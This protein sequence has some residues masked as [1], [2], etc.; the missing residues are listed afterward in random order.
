MRRLIL[1][2]SCL[3]SLPS[4]SFARDVAAPDAAARDAAAPYAVGLASI[5]EAYLR[6]WLEF[7]AAPELAGRDTGKPG[8]DIACRYIESVLKGY[9][10]E[11]AGDEGSFYQEFALVDRK[12]LQDRARIVLEK[13][14]GERVEISLAGQFD[15]EAPGELSWSG[16]I[17]FGARGSGALYDGRDEWRELSED[18]GILLVVPGEDA[19]ADWRRAARLAGARRLLVVDDSRARKKRGFRFRRQPA[20]LIEPFPEGA[21]EVIWIRREI[22]DKLLAALGT[23]LA[24][25]QSADAE[26][27]HFRDVQALVEVPFERKELPSRNV[28]GV[29]RGSDPDLSTEAVILGAHLD[30]VGVRDGKIFYGADDDGSGCSALLGVARA[31]H[32]NGQRPRRSIILQFYGAE[33]LGLHGSRYWSDHPTWSLAD[34]VAMFNLDMIGRDEEQPARGGR[35]ADRPE[36]NRRTIHVVGSKKLSVELDPWIQRVNESIGLEFEYD[37]DRVWRRSDHYNFARKGIPVTFFFAGFHPDYHT[38]RDTTDKI[39][40]DKIV[41]VTRLVY[42]LSYEIADRPRRLSIDRI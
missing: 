39:N 1:V 4:A 24:S 35:P 20:D 17:G 30:H 28:V 2:L 38:P 42:T 5:D 18:G 16:S 12:R 6:P 29:I 37:E 11:P 3:L 40:W 27:L 19:N 26:S 41:R 34:I 22:A 23:D 10:V 25:L 7:L 31:L 21:P 13:A 8:Y 14:G 36:D 9:G 33:E 15:I 32:L